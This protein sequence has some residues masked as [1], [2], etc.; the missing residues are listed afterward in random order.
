MVAGGCRFLLLVRICAVAA[1]IQ[2][3]RFHS[4]EQNSHQRSELFTDSICL[5]QHLLK[6][7]AEPDSSG[8]SAPQPAGFAQGT[9]GA[10][11]PSI[12]QRPQLFLHGE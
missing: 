2:C 9:E 10:V 5:I 7:H 3:F 8:A 4:T 11:D 1:M 6:D 12:V